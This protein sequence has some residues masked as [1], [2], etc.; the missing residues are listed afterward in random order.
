[1]CRLPEDV[2]C[3][4]VEVTHPPVLTQAF[5][6]EQQVAALLEGALRHIN[7]KLG[8]IY[9][10]SCGFV[11]PVGL[12]ASWIR[13]WIFNLFVPYGS[14]SSLHQAKKFKKTLDFYC[15]MTFYDFLS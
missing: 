3:S 2:V 8:T 6:H 7:K 1:V 11:N 9:N 12:L 13:I 14:G 15:Y 5:C 4:A 10:Q